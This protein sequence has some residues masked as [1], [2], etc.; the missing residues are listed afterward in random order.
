VLDFD[1]LRAFVA[2]DAA[3]ERIILVPRGK[4]GVRL[5]PDENLSHRAAASN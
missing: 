5:K 1:L 4:R 3:R 2:V